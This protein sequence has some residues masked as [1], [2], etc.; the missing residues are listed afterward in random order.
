MPAA[1]GVLDAIG[2]GVALISIASKE[3]LYRMSHAVGLRCGSPTLVANAHHHRS[4]AMSSV[5][6][7]FGIAGSALFGLRLVDPLAAGVVG[8]MVL[9]L[10][11]ETSTG[12]H[13]H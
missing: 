12:D 3:A 11:I 6:A 4:D 10:G 1:C 13:D 7:A 9:K 2:L 5:A 8:G